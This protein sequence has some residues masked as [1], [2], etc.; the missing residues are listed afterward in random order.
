VDAIFGPH[1]PYQIPNVL[2]GFQPRNFGKY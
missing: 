1:R 2:T